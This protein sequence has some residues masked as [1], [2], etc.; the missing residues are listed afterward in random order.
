[1]DIRLR[2]GAIPTTCLVPRKVPFALEEATKAEL[3]AMAI[4][5]LIHKVSEPTKW[6]S[7]FLVVLKPKGGIRPVVGYKGLNKYVVRPIHPFLSARAAVESI[8]KTSRF[9]ATL[10]AVKGYWQ[11]RLSDEASRLTTF[12]TPYGRYR[13]TR[14]PMGLSSGDE[15]CR[16]VMKHSR[17]SKASLKW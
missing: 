9:F 16:R 14:A 5:V 12:L 10:D 15:F 6:C 1:M 8:P 17:G 3:A 2:P 11:I 7:S 13:Y 4:S